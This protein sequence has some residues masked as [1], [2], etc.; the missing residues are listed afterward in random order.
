MDDCNRTSITNNNII[1][2]NNHS[3]G[4]CLVSGNM[5]KSDWGDDCINIGD[6]DW[7]DVFQKWNSGS[8]SPSSN[9]HF[10]E[11]YS[12]Y[13]SKVGIYA[14]GSDFDKQLA[15]VP[16]IIGKRVDTETDSSGKLNIKI[17][18]KAGQ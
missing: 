6:T 9:F 15:P 3:G 4:D 17:R 18:V 14:G 13:E 11:N 12:E 1:N 5:C 10:S 7:N 16:Y 2:S 8:I